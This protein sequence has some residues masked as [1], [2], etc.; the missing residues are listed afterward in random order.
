LQRKADAHVSATKFSKTLVRG[1]DAG[2]L[3]MPEVVSL[4]NAHRAALGY[5]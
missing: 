3:A 1:V 4:V 2:L 5:D